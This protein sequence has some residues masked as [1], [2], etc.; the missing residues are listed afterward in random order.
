MT[1]PAITIDQNYILYINQNENNH[2]TLAAMQ[3]EN[4]SQ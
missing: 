2:T 1:K 4:Q 3:F